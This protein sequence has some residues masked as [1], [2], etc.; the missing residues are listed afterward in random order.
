MN[1]SLHQKI[2]NYLDSSSGIALT[3]ALAAVNLCGA[4][5]IVLANYKNGG[6]FWT[7]F[8]AIG[9]LLFI[10]SIAN[11]IQGMARLRRR[12]NSI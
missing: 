7:V 12:R 6:E 11:I 5:F 2:N 3:F 9:F 10:L 1:A 4:I 8:T